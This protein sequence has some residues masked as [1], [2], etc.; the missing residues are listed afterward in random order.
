MYYRHNLT[1]DY[2]ERSDEHM[3]KVKHLR[4][5]HF[6]ENYEYMPKGFWNKF[7]R[8]LLWIVLN[9]LVLTVVKIRH[10]VR[11]FGRKNIRKHK[12]ALK[13][14]AITISNHVFMWDYLCVLMAIHPRL[15][16][17]MAW[18]TNLEGPNGPLISWTGG[19]P[20]PTD[21][22]RAMVKFQ[23][24][25]GELLKQGKWLHVFP[26]G[27]MWYY[28]PDIRP[29][30]KGV[31]KYAVKCDKP[32]LPIAMSFRP[33]KGIFK[34]FGKTPYVDV[35]IGEPLFA[36]KDLSVPDAVDK[37]HAEAYHVVQEMCDIH[38][39]DPTYNTN[40][41]IAEYKKTM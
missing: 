7:K 19:I 11:I 35:H 41:K 8:V 16:Y 9:P 17:Y 40:Q 31:F 3:I 15:P 30:K 28:Y 32:V 38:P 27:S 21:N 14:G 36:D 5:T 34:L 26:E 33:R 20:I 4:D 29:F 18:K 37:M 12:A 13:G 22:R 24:A 39:G 2:P 25:I 10:G 23:D 1:Y 6:D